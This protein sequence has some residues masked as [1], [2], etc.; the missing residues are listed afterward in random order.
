MDDAGGVDPHEHLA[1]P[2]TGLRR[3]LVGERLG[4][5]ASVQSDRFHEYT[6]PFLGL[7]RRDKPRRGV[8]ANHV[9]LIQQGC[10]LHRLVRRFAVACTLCQRAAGTKHTGQ[11]LSSLGVNTTPACRA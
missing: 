2:G 8:V 1:F 3:L 11:V 6:H 7:T 9:Q 10:W 4:A 5:T